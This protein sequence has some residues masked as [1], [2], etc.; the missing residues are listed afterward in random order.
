MEHVNYLQK[1]LGRI[2]V[3]K[4]AIGCLM[5]YLK[6]DESLVRENNGAENLSMLRKIAMNILKKELPN[7]KKISKNIKRFRP[8][9]DEGYLEM[10]VNNI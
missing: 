9:L 4:A 7:E 10:I 1:Q 5:L 6:E 8:A 3:S 2:G